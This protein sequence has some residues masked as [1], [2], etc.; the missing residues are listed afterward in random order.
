MAS[1]VTTSTKALIGLCLAGTVGVIIFLF[2]HLS[3]D[4]R[5]PVKVGGSNAEAACSA[6]DNCLPNV[7]FVDTHGT[8]YTPKTLAGK[9]VVVNFWATWC[10]P[11]EHEIP[12]FSRVYDKHKDKDV[13]ILGV[14]AGDDP[15]PSDLLNFQSDHMMTYP[16]IRGD[17]TVIDAFNRPRNLPT[18]FIY[19]R[20]GKQVQ[21]KVGAL[22]EK[23]LL[24]ILE[25]LL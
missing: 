22:R 13:I 17:D 8:A 19:D 12:D 2:V 25:P 23:Q 5:R 3:D 15:S 6:S 21:M 18:T 20:N 7:T 16:V 9:V 11:C 10:G 24:D 14:L 1:G 4:P